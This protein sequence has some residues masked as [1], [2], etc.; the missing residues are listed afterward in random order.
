MFVRSCNKALVSVSSGIVS[1]SSKTL[2]PIAAAITTTSRI[3]VRH[4][5]IV[6]GAPPISCRDIYE[7]PYAI[8]PRI[9]VEERPP[10]EQFEV[11]MLFYLLFCFI[12]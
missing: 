10:Q 5:T 1:R 11:V 6:E 3:S 9:T 7:M 8:W 12:Y 2:L 4:A